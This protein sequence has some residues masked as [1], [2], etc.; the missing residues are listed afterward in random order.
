MIIVIIIIII[1]NKQLVVLSVRN[2][3]C[4]GKDGAVQT[5]I[6]H[7]CRSES[8][9]LSWKLSYSK[10]HK[11]QSAMKHDSEQLHP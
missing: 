6:I 10:Y 2:E 3:A 1:P 5:E 9:N 11:M 8:R 7:A 4:K